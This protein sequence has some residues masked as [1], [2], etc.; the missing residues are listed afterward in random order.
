MKQK[1]YTLS[2]DV[3]LLESIDSEGG[4]FTA[5][6]HALASEKEYAASLGSKDAILRS[7]FS[8]QLV[9]VGTLQTVVDEISNNGY[10]NVI[11]FGAGTAC[12]E[13]ILKLALPDNVEVM[14]SDF[15]RIF[16]EKAKQFF[17]EIKPIQFD[18]VSDDIN[19]IRN[20]AHGEVD[21]AV[22]FASSYVLD[23][24]EF[25]KLFSSMKDIGVKR[26]IDFHGGYMDMEMFVYYLMRQIMRNRL[27][28]RILKRPPLPDYKGKFH[29]FSRNR[30]ELRRL[31]KESGLRIISEQSVCDFKYVATLEPITE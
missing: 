22:F 23:D 18:F 14:A 29:G 17:P 20:H 7:F 4:R 13:Y 15:D 31:Y 6:E 21:M 27:I 1:M 10:R 19:V 2:Y 25:V 28:R 16:V 8:N 30:R 11:S 5:E 24:E 12:R 9:S 3:K 26:I